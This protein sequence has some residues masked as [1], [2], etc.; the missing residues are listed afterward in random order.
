MTHYDAAIIGAGPAGMAAAVE[1]RCSGL[2]TVVLDEQEAPGGQIY[3]G[4]ERAD[5]SRLKVL[6]SDYAE[7]GRLAADFRAS[8]AIYLPGSTVWNV[9]R[10]RGIDYSRAGVPSGLS[11]AAIIVASGAV[12]R[13][14][15]T[16][17]WT[18]PGV[19][20][21]G[22]CQILL[23]AHGLVEEDVVFVGSGPLVWLIAAQMVGA[24]R[25]P[26]AIVE[27]V[28]RARYAAALP[29]LPLNGAAMRY[30]RKGAAMMRAVRRAGIPVFSGATDIAIAGSDKAE[31]V[32]FFAG[33]QAHRVTANLVA[34]HQGVVPNQQITRL[35]RCDHTWNGGQRCFVPRLDP[36][37]E[38]SVPNI[39][40]AGDGGG[41]GGARAAALQGQL[42]AS[43]IAQRLGRPS[44]RDA[45]ALQS[46]LRKELSIRR[47]LETL[48]APSSEILA[49]ADGT[50]VCRCE[51]VTAG[52]IRAAVAS[53]APGPNQVKSLLRPGMGPCQGRMCGLSV[54]EIIAECRGETPSTVDYYRIRPP[55]KPLA[56]SELAA[57]GDAEDE[58]ALME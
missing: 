25:K 3:R 45:A 21:A 19:V 38:T 11:A 34:L 13:P 14:T 39:Y 2:S 53:G 7:G 42:A 48:Y 57:F 22:A 26:K 24:G 47:F 40:V 28:P 55:L 41:V 16:P 9:G 35:L 50:L 36:F 1:C 49:P 51:E 4:I 30:L 33:G 32:T 8:G 17:G 56:L 23:K 15:P 44:G 27:T 46:R 37:G 20:T 18:L 52:Q 29:R 12:E 5:S 54:V 31:A 6:G 43:R 10:E 58:A